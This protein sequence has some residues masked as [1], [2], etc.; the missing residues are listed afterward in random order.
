M[1]PQNSRDGLRSYADTS[2]R[3]SNLFALEKSPGVAQ[4]QAEPVGSSKTSLPFLEA[5]ATNWN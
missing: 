2:L 1:L 5:K 3:H 4:P